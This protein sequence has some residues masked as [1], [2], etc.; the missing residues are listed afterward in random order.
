LQN[1]KL[2]DSCAPIFKEGVQNA[3]LILFSHGIQAKNDGL[4]S[5]RVPST[6]TSV[7]KI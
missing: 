5:K 2:V 7:L 3:G 4:N 6:S 1:S